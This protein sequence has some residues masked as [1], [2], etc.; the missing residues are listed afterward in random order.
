MKNMAVTA[1]WENIKIELPENGEKLN[2]EINTDNTW[3]EFY[4]GD[5]TIGFDIMPNCCEYFFV[6][7]DDKYIYDSQLPNDLELG[8]KGTL[9][10][11]ITNCSIT[12]INDYECGVYMRFYLNGKELCFCNVHNGYYSHTLVIHKNDENIFVT[13]L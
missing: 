4:L 13:S 8:K 3:I 10:E 9:A 6:S 7:Y 11:D 1:D 12:M 2:F 5:Y